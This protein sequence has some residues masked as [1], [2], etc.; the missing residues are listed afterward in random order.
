M[1]QPL[2]FALVGKDIAYSRSPEIFEAIYRQVRWPGRFELHSV[3]AGDLHSRIRQAV[4]DGVRGFSVT[5]PFKQEVIRYLDD[6]DPTAQAVDAVNSIAVTEGRL[7]GYNTDCHGF[8]EP[9]RELRPLLRSGKALILG[10]G[11]AARASI[12]A[13]YRN[14]DIKRFAVVG[15]SP[16]KL[17]RLKTFF[18]TSPHHLEVEPHPASVKN[19]KIL[20][21][22]D[23]A[24]NC[25][26][27]GGP[28]SPE[29]SPLP[30]GFDFRSLKVYYDLNYNDNNRIVAAARQAGIRAFDG[31]SMLV[32]QALRSFDIWTGQSVEFQPIFDAVFGADRRK[33]GR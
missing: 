8:S 11:G 29:D 30:E 24:V 26:P 27:L 25:T 16:E 31:S 28:H 3:G 5:I 17:E 2:Y 22:V 14:F 9:L 13:L 20:G 19:S 18:E 10:T 15:R 12:Y 23:I 4:L 21:R 33:V 1:K 7:L 6:I 32:S